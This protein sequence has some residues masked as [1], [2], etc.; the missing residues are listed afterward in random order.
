MNDG[1]VTPDIKEIILCC[2]MY[3]LS[4]RWN[5]VD[6][7][8]V[9][10]SDISVFKTDDTGADYVIWMGEPEHWLY[11]EWLFFLFTIAWW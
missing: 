5:H 4:M 8:D 10:I 11:C 9:I 2:V 1:S 7:L 6:L 3:R